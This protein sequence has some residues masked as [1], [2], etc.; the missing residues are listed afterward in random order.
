MMGKI[1]MQCLL[2]G[3]SMICIGCF[4]IN[5]PVVYSWKYER[6]ID[7]TGYNVP[8]RIFPI[9]VGVLLLLVSKRR[10]S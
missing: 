8:I 7:L 2:A 10:D 3:I 1:S 9:I 4:M 6:F 5:Y